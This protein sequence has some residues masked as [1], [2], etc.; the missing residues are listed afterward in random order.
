MA[1]NKEEDRQQGVFAIIAALSVLFSSMINPIISL[2]LS[3]TILISFGVW[4][5]IKK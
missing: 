4:K 1:K 5:L 3:S 2:I